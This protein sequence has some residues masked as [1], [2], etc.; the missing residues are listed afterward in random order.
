MSNG[1]SLKN[2]ALQ[3][4]PC[5]L[6]RDVETTCS[7][8]EFAL[9]YEAVAVR[10]GFAKRVL[11]P[12]LGSVGVIER[13]PAVSCDVVCGAETDTANLG[14]ETVRLPREHSHRAAPVA[15]DDAVG[16]CLADSVSTERRVYLAVNL[17]LLPVGHDALEPLATD[18]LY[19]Q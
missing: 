5:R 1:A 13:K 11:K 18:P 3:A 2:E 12:R 4:A 7:L 9:R 10:L 17:I 6:G 16:E 8:K 15:I 19:G 14:S